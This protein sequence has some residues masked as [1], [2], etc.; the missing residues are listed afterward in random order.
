MELRT[1]TL[2]STRRRITAVLVALFAVIATPAALETTDS[3]DRTVAEAASDQ[4]SSLVAPHESVESYAELRFETSLDYEFPDPPQPRVVDD[5]E[6]TLRL[7]EWLQSHGALIEPTPSVAANVSAVNWSSGS[8]SEF[9]SVRSEVPVLLEVP[10]LS[11]SATVKGVGINGSREMEIPESFNTVGWYRYG[12][13]PGDAG[14][15][16]IAGHLDDQN[17]RSVFFNLRK[18]EVGAIV[19]VT[20]RD[21]EETAFR[22]DEK[23]SYDSTKLP[24]EKIFTREGE[25][26]LALITCGGRWD[27]SAGRYTETVVV[28]ATPVA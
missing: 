22:V 27:E 5:C 9:T 12:P 13:T 11:I 25:P 2:T 4:S 8:Y 21:G 1:V 3:F 6:R 15:S 14:T 16:V 10:S 28:Y 24:S 23:R 7:C 26:R 19:I 17:G 20:S 18:V